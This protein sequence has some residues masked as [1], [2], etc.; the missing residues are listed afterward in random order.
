VGD[1]SGLSD[2]SGLVKQKIA[3]KTKKK[4]RMQIN[5]N[6]NDTVGDAE[7]KLKNITI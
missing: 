4:L 2:N 1:I 6:V 5:R 3:L 7:N